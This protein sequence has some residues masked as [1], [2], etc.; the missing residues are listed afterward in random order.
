MTVSI[1]P[2]R[3]RALT[4][5][6]AAVLVTAGL[7]S[8][9][10]A[11]DESGGGQ[12][13]RPRPD[14][15]VQLLAFN[16]YHGH[17]ESSTPGTVGTV[18]AGGSEFLSTHLAA[19]RAGH[20]NSL[21]VAAGDLIGGTP[22]LSGLFHDEPSVESLNAMG[23]DVSSVGNH[24][25]DEGVTELLRM[26]NGGCHPVDGCYFDGQ[27]FP[28]AD[29]PWLAA[30]VKDDLGRT[31]LPPY[32][33]KRFQGVQVG[34]IG[35]TLEGTDALVAQS[36]IRGWDFTDEV[37]TANALVPQLRRQ[38]VQAIVV[39]LHEGGI[40][41]GTYD[42]CVGIS[43]PIV[44]IAENL[45]PEIDAVITG[46]THQPYNCSI[47]DPAGQPRAVTSAFSFGRII[48][49][50]NLSIDTRTKDVR[51]DQTTVVNHIVTQDVARD[52]VLTSIIAKWKSISDAVGSE[53][54]GQVAGSIVRRGDRQLESD[55]GNL[56][57]DAQLWA[58]QDNGAQLA[59]MNPGGLRADLVFDSPLGTGGQVTFAEAFNVQP[60]GNLLSTI[61]MTGQQIIDVLKQQCQPAGSSRPFLFLGVSNGLSYTL[62]RT[63]AAGV[64][65]SITV[66]DVR[67][68]GVALDP[69]ATY[70]V[71]VNNFLV[72]G[73]DN[74]TV[75]AQVNPALRVGGGIDLDAFVA[76][77]AAFS[78][79]ASPGI[80]RVNEVFVGG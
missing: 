32:W 27:T 47:P 65:T 41:S 45:D 63:I 18:P 59:L 57:A 34:F 30:N 35:M 28:G 5:A 64:C 53:V 69:A 52:P 54:V 26:Q 12:S 72:D 80:G 7:A 37:E 75:F 9:P 49:E 2:R 73:G 21:T 29:F 61:P 40:Q 68:N 74:F 78:P 50:L 51:R 31:P 60:F 43:G 55:L 58:T 33:I 1:P 44:Q 3:L 70:Q 16:D 24:E 38:G 79:V 56:V 77:F 67:L 22:F 19:L 10:A 48:T 76:Y 71:T 62:D 15:Q 23:L 36:G 46:H 39:L 13:Q 6:A 20:R 14:V 17:L 66:S 42:E 11:A 8:T 4:A 25:F